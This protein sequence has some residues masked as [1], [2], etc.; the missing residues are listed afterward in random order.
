MWPLHGQGQPGPS[1]VSMGTSAGKAANPGQIHQ[2]SWLSREIPFSRKKLSSVSVSAP[3][4]NL[5]WLPSAQTA[6]STLFSL[7][8]IPI[9]PPSKSPLCTPAWWSQLPLL[10][11]AEG[12]MPWRL[13]TLADRFP[14]PQ[15]GSPSS[16]RLKCW[17]CSQGGQAEPDPALLFSA[18][19]LQG[20]GSAQISEHSLASALCL[21][22]SYTHRT[23]RVALPA[24]NTQS[25]GGWGTYVEIDRDNSCGDL[26]EIP[27]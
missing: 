13:L 9:F 4:K 26:E 17:G 7:G 1:G 25:G 19:W 2:D 23:W 22:L 10:R 5:Q 21:D 3:I 16:S 11:R 27:T 8:L 14:A 12:E 15:P 24:R 18:M 20:L 6:K